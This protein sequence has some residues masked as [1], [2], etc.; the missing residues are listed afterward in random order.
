[1]NLNQDKNFNKF[2]N[3]IQNLQIVTTEGSALPTEARLKK[4]DGI[5]SLSIHG[6]SLSPKTS[7]MK[8]NT[9]INIE[10]GDIKVKHH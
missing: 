4:N 3:I 7:Q 6:R 10:S 1:M 8:M 2:T 5:S 9:F